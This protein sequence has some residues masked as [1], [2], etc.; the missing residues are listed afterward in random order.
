MKLTCQFRR[1]LV[2]TFSPMPKNMKSERLRDDR[3][4]D[5]DGEKGRQRNKQLGSIPLKATH[6]IASHGGIDWAKLVTAI[7]QFCTPENGVAARASGGTLVGKRG[8]KRPVWREITVDA[9]CCRGQWRALPGDP[10]CGL[11]MHIAVQTT[12][13]HNANI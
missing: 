11:C 9:D 12:H 1:F 10:V 5:D 3:K 6:R 4:G 8:W 13:P 2:R 7:P